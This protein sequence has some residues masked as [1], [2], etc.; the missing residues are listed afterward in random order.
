LG[1]VFGGEDFREAGESL[2]VADQ[3]DHGG[4]GQ[5]LGGTGCRKW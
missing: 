5:L 1:Q 4:H 3:D 2:D